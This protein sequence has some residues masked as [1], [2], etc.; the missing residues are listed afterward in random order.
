M[1]KLMQASAEAQAAK[2]Q[3]LSNLMASSGSGGGLRS[4]DLASAYTLDQPAMPHDYK[5][6]RAARERAADT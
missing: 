2:R 6:E 4:D 3:R 1:L 5:R